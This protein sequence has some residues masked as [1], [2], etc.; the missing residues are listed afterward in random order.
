MKGNLTLFVFYAGLVVFFWGLSGNISAQSKQR[1]PYKEKFSSFDK[2]IRIEINIDNFLTDETKKEHEDVLEIEADATDSY[3]LEPVFFNT[4]TNKDISISIVNFNNAELSSLA[5]KEPWIFNRNTLNAEGTAMIKLNI[6]PTNKDE[7]S[8]KFE[9]NSNNKKYTY[10]IRCKFVKQRGLVLD[11]SK[12]VNLF[13][14]ETLVIKTSKGKSKNEKVF[15]KNEGDS[16]ITVIFSPNFEMTNQDCP[17]FFTGFTGEELVLG[18][19]ESKALIINFEWGTFDDINRS[20]CINTSISMPS[21]DFFNPKEKGIFELFSKDSAPTVRFETKESG[22]SIKFRI[23]VQY[24]YEPLFPDDLFLWG[25]SVLVFIVATTILILIIRKNRNKPNKEEGQIDEKTTNL[26]NIAP[27][28]IKKLSPK[29]IENI[30]NDLKLQLM[31]ISGKKNKIKNKYFGQIEEVRRKF[32]LPKPATSTNKSNVSSQDVQDASELL[33]KVLSLSQ[34]NSAQYSMNIKDFL[35]ALAK[36]FSTA[37]HTINKFI[38]ENDSKLGHKDSSD[39]TPP[40]PQQEPAPVA[41]PN[42]EVGNNSPAQSP[43][44]T[45]TPPTPSTEKVESISEF[46]SQIIKSFGGTPTQDLLTKWKEKLPGILATLAQTFRDRLAQNRVDP[47]QIVNGLQ[48]LDQK[49]GELETKQK[50]LKEKEAKLEVL[51]KEL[52]NLKRKV[53]LGNDASIE[54]IIIKIDEKDSQIREEKQDK[55][56]FRRAKEKEVQDLKNEQLELNR[57]QNLITTQLEI[58]YSKTTNHNHERIQYLRA[59]PEQLKL[60]LTNLDIDPGLAVTLTDLPKIPQQVN[61]R[62][63]RL[64]Q[65]S[66]QWPATFRLIYQMLQFLQDNLYVISR[67]VSRDSPFVQPINYIISGEKGGAGLQRAK[68]VLDDKQKLL[69]LFGLTSI[70]GLH[71]LTSENIY[72]DF[73]IPY[74]LKDVIDRVSA[75][76]HYQFIK[77]THYDL[78]RD[79]RDAGISTDLV[80]QMYFGMVFALEGSI[81]LVIT[82]NPPIYLGATQFEENL[83]TE[84]AFN[85]IGRY[86]NNRYIGLLNDIPSGT[87]YDLIDVGY[88]F[89]SETLTEERK[90]KVA[91]R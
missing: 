36:V 55:E 89:K 78:G 71:D 51:Q 1:E 68:D 53:N 5:N 37:E 56:E 60:V 64:N 85:N 87:I 23:N 19:H 33:A 18:P 39:A 8:I 75:L 14:E 32:Q 52:V 38:E 54:A 24:E 65:I 63:D 61:R 76:Y 77:T 46:L 15:L 67:E 30:V 45:Q 86:G 58:P 44:N 20:K 91:K 62:I 81:G 74:C 88:K 31:P 73:I 72:K 84:S 22:Q 66:D 47:E 34:N 25:L 7:H 41:P 42:Q 43:I 69:G 9:F 26:E 6:K 35:L 90:A 70:R 16:P 82:N 11:Q 2:P 40:P 4:T 59:V 79:M 12:M 13:N 29:L 50:E 57:F 28:P 83:Y 17:I 3:I 10:N 49:I 21:S 80:S 27:T 48:H